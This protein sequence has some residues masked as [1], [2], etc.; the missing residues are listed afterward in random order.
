MDF[1]KKTEM[2]SGFMHTR[3]KPNPYTYIILNSQTLTLT[4]LSL[5][6]SQRLSHTNVGHPLL[7]ILTNHNI[8][9]NPCCRRHLSSLLS[10]LSSSL[11]YRHYY[12]HHH[13][14]R[15]SDSKIETA[16]SQ[17][18]ASQRSYLFIAST[19]YHNSQTPPKLL[20]L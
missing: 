18:R 2:G 9:T 4:S 5:S 14:Y 19:H 16:P 1:K 10:Q 17:Y 15:K 6:L 3:P 13:L 11:H 12:Y 7:L 8:N 20:S